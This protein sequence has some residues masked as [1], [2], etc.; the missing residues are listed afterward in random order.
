MKR[1]LLPLLLLTSMLV[2][3]EDERTIYRQKKQISE[4]KDIIQKLKRDKKTTSEKLRKITEEYNQMPKRGWD[5]V[6]KLAQKVGKNKDKVGRLIVTKVTYLKTKNK[7]TK[8]ELKEVKEKLKLKTD[9]CNNANVALGLSLASDLADFVAQDYY[10]NDDRVYSLINDWNKATDSN[11]LYQ[12]LRS[13]ADDFDCNDTWTGNHLHF[14]DPENS[15]DNYVNPV[16]ESLGYTAT[17]FLLRRA[18]KT[19]TVNEWAEKIGYNKLHKLAKIALTESGL[20]A[21]SHILLFAEKWLA[22]KAFGS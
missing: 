3:N 2:C 7:K 22:K 15:Y 9:H 4:L 11:E 21:T 17:N 18:G 5:D 16:A 14:Y 10:D 6:L 20:L 13:T 1:Q 19:E 8:K 12:F